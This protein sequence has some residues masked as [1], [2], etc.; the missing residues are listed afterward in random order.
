M[1]SLRSNYFTLPTGTY[2]TGTTVEIYGYKYP[3]QD[4]RSGAC[5][6]GYL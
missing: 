4:C 2:P 1:G 3:I 6:P 5:Y